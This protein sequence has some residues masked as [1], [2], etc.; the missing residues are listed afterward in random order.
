VA[1]VDPEPI[2]P[3]MIP[4]PPVGTPEANVVY[5]TVVVTQRVTVVQHETVTMFT[6]VKAPR[7]GLL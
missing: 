6:T 5:Q 4:A 1:P 7:R 3:T 2:A